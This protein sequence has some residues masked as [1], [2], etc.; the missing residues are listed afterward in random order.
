MRAPNF[1]AE[2]SNALVMT[3]SAGNGP[4]STRMSRHLRE[5][6]IL[7]EAVHA[8]GE[9]RQRVHDLARADLAA[10]RI[11]RRG[12][13]EQQHVAAA[14]GGG[15]RLERLGRRIDDEEL[16]VAARIA[17]ITAGA[18][19][20]GRF[21]RDAFEREVDL[22]HARER[23]RLVDADLR[24]GKGMLA[25]LEDEALVGPDRLVARHRPRSRRSRW[26]GAAGGAAAGAGGAGGGA[27]L[28]PKGR[29]P[30]ALPLP[31][32]ERAAQ[33]SQRTPCKK[34]RAYSSITTPQ[35]MRPTGTEMVALRV[36]A[37]MMVMSSP[38][39][40]ATNSLL[41]SLESVMPQERLPTRM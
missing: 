11:L 40:L 7:H 19:S 34:R 9:A 25:G 29:A 20:A 15:E 2:F 13:V 26:S 35:G 22:E 6:E 31:E 39:P 1:F 41:S 5:G 27:C 18:T 16:D 8:H 10:Q 21:H 23:R 28:A 12:G 38:K 37:S 24:A 36:F 14:H 3:A 32:G 4:C 17:C 33:R 30:A